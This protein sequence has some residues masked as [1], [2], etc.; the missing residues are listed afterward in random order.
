MHEVQVFKLI[1]SLI[2][3]KKTNQWI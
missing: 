3:N 2:C 1:V